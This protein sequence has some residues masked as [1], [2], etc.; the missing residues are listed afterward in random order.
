MDSALASLLNLGSSF[1]NTGV[2]PGRSGNRHPSI[3]PYE[4]FAAADRDI[5]LAGGNDAIFERLCGVLGRPELATD[6]RFATNAER[7][8]HRDAL[9][10][11]LEA[12]FAGDT[13]EAWAE[14]LNAAGVPAGP[15]NDVGEAFALA[16]RL[17]LEPVAELDGVR[18]ARSPLRL[19]DDARRCRGCARRASASTTTS[20]APGSA[21]LRRQRLADRLR[22]H[23]AHVLLDDLELRDVRRCRARGRTATSRWTSSSG[24]LAPEVIPTVS[25]PSSHSSSTCASL[26]IRCDVGAVLARDLDEAVRVRGVARADHEHEVALRRELLDGGLAVRRGVTDVVGARPDDVREALAQ[27]A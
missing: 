2:V 10:A 26:S 23:E 15:V 25:T 24:A 6:P 22:E 17:G 20:C 9:G 14:R 21:G 18:T 11:E 7:V 4:T 19:G 1:L 5:A 3:A 27:R 16:E 13:A 12:A 8:G